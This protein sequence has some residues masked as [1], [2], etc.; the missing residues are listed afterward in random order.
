MISIALLWKKEISSAFVMTRE[1]FVAL[2]HDVSQTGNP[3]C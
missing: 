3:L 2:F 1:G